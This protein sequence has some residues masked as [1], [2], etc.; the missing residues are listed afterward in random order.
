MRTNFESVIHR[1]SVSEIHEYSRQDY[2]LLT[3]WPLQ[4]V[5]VSLPPAVAM[6][7][8]SDLV[9]LKKKDLIKIIRDGFPMKRHP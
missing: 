9:F 5:N 1:E 4:Q 6:T 2:I 7:V 3:F 8:L